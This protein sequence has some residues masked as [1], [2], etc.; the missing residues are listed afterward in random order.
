MGL[1]DLIDDIGDGIENLADG[2]EH[3]VGKGIDT[4]AHVAGDGLDALG[5]H[6]AAQAVDNFGDNVADSLGAQVDEQQ[7]GQTDDPTHLIH[8]D[9]GKIRE[10]VGH[11]KKF[12]GAFAETSDGLKRIDSSHWEG[13]AA[14]GFRQKYHGH[15]QQW[16]DAEDACGKAAQALDDYSHT[17]E[18]AQGQAKQAI[19]LYNQAKQDSKNARDAYNT[20]V[21]NYNNQ[22]NAYNSAV[23][24]GN[25]PGPMPQPLSEFHDPGVEKANQA[26][27]ILEDARKARNDA[28]GKAKGAIDAATNKA[29]A[30]PRFTDR[31]LNDAGDLLQ[32]ANVGMEH[33]LGGVLK[34]AGDIVKF[35]RGLNPL[36]PYNITHP[37]AYLTGLSGT[38]TGLLHAA[39]H[40]VDLLKGLVG[41]GWGSDPFEAFGK[42][43]P[44]VALAAATDGA[45]AA[46]GL[47][48]RAAVD[49][50]ERAGVDAGE[51]AAA[52]ANRFAAAAD[53]SGIDLSRMPEKPVWRDTTEPLYRSDG[54]DPSVIFQEGF[55]PLNPDEVN[56]RQFV[57]TNNPSAF[58]S[59]TR[60]PEL[61]KN[62]GKEFRYEV[63]APGGIDVNQSLGPHPLQHEAEIAF[64][65]GVDPRFIKGVHRVNPDGSLGEWIPNPNF[66]PN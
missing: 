8:G 58:V 27:Q 15:A 24:S 41:D 35:A 36:D 32:G 38:V 37:A 25:D 18:W 52:D 63:E 10:S 2:A 6:G 29:P 39:N 33:M 49:V 14:D 50:G 42:L 17:V 21:D 55:K 19:E 5:L 48:E 62:W 53:S 54:R 60:D 40:P 26:K 64:P 47:G 23:Q 56:L 59:T 22:V 57:N 44:N 12:S 1:G 4:V 43:V 34:G 45:G 46:E 31:M 51:N 16:L 7:L 66:H 61:Y 13:A 20:Q 9:V 30:E 11:L 65:G 28:A 3:L